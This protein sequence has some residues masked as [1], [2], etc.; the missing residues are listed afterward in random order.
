VYAIVLAILLLDEQRELSWPFYLG[1]G[2]ILAVVLL[3]AKVMERRP[4]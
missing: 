2:I 1:V 3:H 4:G